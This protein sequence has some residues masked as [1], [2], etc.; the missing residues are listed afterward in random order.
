MRA[1]PGSQSLLLSLRA[2]AL[3]AVSDERSL[4]ANHA[5]YALVSAA[6]TAEDPIDAELLG[7]ALGRI[8]ADTRVIVRMAADYASGR[9]PLLARAESI[10]AAAAMDLGPDPNAWVAAQRTLGEQHAERELKKA[11]VPHQ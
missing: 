2:A 1:E 3:L 11:R 4:L 8:R 5:A 10:R 6:E 9:L 7:A